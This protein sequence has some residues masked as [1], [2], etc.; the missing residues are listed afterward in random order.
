MKEEKTVSIDREELLNL[1]SFVVEID[2]AGRIVW[3]SER[4]RCFLADANL[5][6][7]VLSEVA[8]ESAAP[9]CPLAFVKDG[10]QLRARGSWI[11]LPKD[12][13]RIFVGNPAP[14][15]MAETERLGLVIDDFVPGDPSFVSL[16]LREE[17]EAATA[18]L[19]DRIR[20]LGE[21][22][23]A[24]L[25]MVEEVATAR[26]QAEA[27][28]ELTQAI[29]RNLPV[30]ILVIG[31]DMVVRQANPTLL[32]MVGAASEA[33]VVGKSCDGLICAVHNG[34][35]PIFDLGRTIHRSEAALIRANK[36][37]LPVLKSAYP[38]S[39][40]G[41]HVVVEA[42]VDVSEQ[43]AAAE[44]ARTYAT[45][46]ELSNAELQHA[47]AQ[48]EAATEVKGRFLANMSHEIRTPMNGI[49]GMA[50]LALGTDLTDEQREYLEGVKTSADSLLRILNDVLDYS[51]IEAGWVDME[52]I[53]FSISEVVEN[54]VDILSP[55][56]CGD[57]VELI[58]SVAPDVP[59]TVLGDPTRVRQVLLNLAGNAAK[60]TGE[61][62]VVIRAELE[63]LRE[64]RAVVVFS[65]ADTGIGIPAERIDRVFDSF[66]QGDTSTTRKYGGTGLGLAISKHLVEVMDGRIWVESEPDRG[67][68][69][70]FSIPFEVEEQALEQDVEGRPDQPA[71]IRGLKVLVVDDN[72][73]N[74]TILR[75]SLSSWGCRP[76]E[77][78]G[79]KEALSL[80][81]GAASD[82]FQLVL[83][84]GQMP[85]MDGFALAEA[86]AGDESL[87]GLHII[88]L[89]SMGLRLSEER[90]RGLGISATLAK[91]VKQSQLLDT[92]M[93]VMVGA[94]TVEDRS[95]QP[96]SV[97]HRKLPKGVRVLLA[98]DNVVNQRVVRKVLEKA[99]CVV[100][101]VGDGSAALA[102]LEQQ[103]YDLVLM[104]VQM[105]VMDGFEATAAIRADQRWRTLPVIAMTAH[106][107]KGDRERCLNAGMSDYI[108]KPV[109]TA[110]MFELIEQWVDPARSDA[111]DDAVGEDGEES[112]PAHP[113]AIEPPVNLDDGLGRVDGDAE[114]WYEIAE[115]LVNDAPGR[116]EKI[117]RA[118]AAGDGEAVREQAHSMKG[119]AGTLGAKPL[120][121]AAAQLETAARES[122]LS[123]MAGGLAKL[124]EEFSRFRAFVAARREAA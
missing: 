44:E 57:E 120:Q 86:I 108:P 117:E 109:D 53:P 61:G 60:F 95:L 88:M 122:R 94:G 10:A 69:F 124:Q 3:A 107:L 97:T 65:V 4:L 50:E 21:R 52:S 17:L 43:K 66:T 104:D 119:A 118:L 98:E 46:L 1:G 71:D 2:G 99:G 64:T 67:S 38:V 29:L 72:L 7:T 101:V 115:L 121:Q 47:R 13:G 90:A 87:R 30:G 54:V 110:R 11:E 70:S 105:P 58:C 45:E 12:A 56:T 25:R 8:V 111:T 81:R 36:D 31:R 37:E 68:V 113:Q 40:G 35:C 6:G 96:K 63:E 73:T 100:D 19:T 32:Q 78:A 16:F 41:E 59:K 55:K 75:E 74:R 85:E 123:D 114:L 82:P 27:S 5:E 28:N 23:E 24:T 102:A 116:I 48:A 20:E 83:L 14:V 92:L 112:P 80:L 76:A 39:I 22:Q 34:A 77:A 15:S 9:G 93:N 51:K 91:P 84:D 89:T 33:D 26:A 49:I 42:L 18:D 103:Q 79:G 62:E 106:A